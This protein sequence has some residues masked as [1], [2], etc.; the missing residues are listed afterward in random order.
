MTDWIY[1]PHYLILCNLATGSVI[2]INFHYEVTKNS[3]T[4]QSRDE[5]TNLIRTFTPIEWMHQSAEFQKSDYSGYY[6]EGADK[7]YIRRNYYEV[8]E[9]EQ[10]HISQHFPHYYNNVKPVGMIGAIPNSYV[11]DEVVVTFVF[12]L[13]HHFYDPGRNK[14]I[15]ETNDEKVAIEKLDSLAESTGAFTMKGF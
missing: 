10:N 4:H 7:K 2:R 15:I 9:A 8:N 12:E 1:K 5:R 3:T 13:T 11:A 14:T 6:K